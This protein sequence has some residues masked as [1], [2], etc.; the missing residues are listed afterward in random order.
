MAETKGESSA[1]S[2]FGV[3]QI[4][5]DNH[6]LLECWMTGTSLFMLLPTRKT[7]FDDLYALTRYPC[8]DSWDHLLSFMLHGLELHPLQTPVDFL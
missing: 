5:S 3:H 4:P 1:Q 2:M 6:T 7:F 8:F